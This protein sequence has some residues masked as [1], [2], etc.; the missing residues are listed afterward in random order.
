MSGEL[1]KP[2]G[3]RNPGGFD[4]SAYLARKGIFGIIY[5]KKADDLK[6]VGEGDGIFWLRWMDRLRGKIEKIFDETMRDTPNYAGIL[7]GIILGKKKALPENILSAFRNSGVMHLL[8]VSGLHV[9]MIA[10]ACFSLFKFLRLPE[11]FI[12][13]LT[14]ILLIVYASLVGYRPS[15]VRAS[16]IIILFFIAKII[17]RDSDLLNLLG[18]AALL[19]LLFNIT[20]LWDVGFQLS[21]A[22]TA[23]I[24]YLMPK[25][26]RLIS[27][28]MQDAIDRSIFLRLANKFL[29]LPIGVSVAAQAASLPIIAYHFNSIYTVTVLTN[30]VAVWLVWYIVCV[31]FVTIILCLIFPPLAI[32]FAHANKLT[33][34]LLLKVVH[35]F[36]GIPHAV[37]EGLPH[38][39]CFFVTGVFFAIANLDW[40]RKETKKA[41]IIALAVI[42]LYLGYATIPRRATSGGYVS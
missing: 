15:V 16:I 37:V 5:L 19:L 17:D 4:Y 28:A 23:A 10:L 40:I 26:Q 29:L 32:P 14:M 25:W 8:A 12:Y 13:A 21:F 30:L 18:F 33:I 42:S 22:V 27:F 31:A 39:L 3:K 1:H 35:F 41:L 11:K 9:G 36:A 2:Q 6:K 7:K 38:S 20:S 34:F 24:V